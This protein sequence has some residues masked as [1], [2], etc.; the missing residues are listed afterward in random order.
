MAA[1]PAP[2]ERLRHLDVAKGIGIVLL[3][4]GHFVE[5]LFLGRPE[6]PLGR[7]FFLEWK[8]IYAFHMPLFFFVA[9]FL[10]EAR[11]DASFR[12]VQAQV[13]GYLHPYLVAGVGG[14]LV[15][16]GL[17]LASGE[18]GAQLLAD[19][20]REVIAFALR[21]LAG[22]GPGIGVT[23]FLAALAEVLVLHFLL[24]RT[25]LSLPLR[26]VLF[27]VLGGVA[28]MVL[29]TNAL[30]VR[31]LG[32]CTALFLLGVLC[33]RHQARFDAFIRSPLAF[34]AGAL[35]LLLTFG[36]NDS[37]FARRGLTELERS[38]GFAVLLSGGQLGN[39]LLFALT[40]V[41][42]IAAAIS[43]ARR[44]RSGALAAIGAV[45]LEMFILNGFLWKFAN[46]P[47]ADCVLRATTD[48]LL[49]HVA[50]LA[51]VAASLALCYAAAVLLRTRAPFVLKP[52][53][54]GRLAAP[55]R[56]G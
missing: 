12:R 45:S 54:A 30:Q 55:A 32:A 21:G 13:L 39:P 2:P 24:S 40:A 50:A 6:T 53:W 51:I 34:L 38:Y 25:A 49:L 31:S 8:A 48:P 52:T 43:A 47:L 9:G 23:W 44:V 35:V 14:L 18:G 15:A 33:R 28:S 1:E 3:F 42:G 27:A 5:H 11:G 10:A 29:T 20:R 7:V 37:A 4:Y 41:A 22:Q 56:G 26:L 16:V 19:L 36:L 17:L 46:R